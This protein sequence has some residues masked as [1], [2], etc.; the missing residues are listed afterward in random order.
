MPFVDFIL[1]ADCCSQ[2]L[3]TRASCPTHHFA[4]LGTGLAVVGLASCCD[5]AVVAPLS[6]HCG[7]TECTS[8]ALDL[9]YVYSVE[10]YIFRLNEILEEFGEAKV[11]VGFG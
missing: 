7:K 3:L 1:P 4:F 10:F 5:C 11:I 2:P 8:A 6:P 9:P